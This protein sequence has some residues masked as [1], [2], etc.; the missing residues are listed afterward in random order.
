MDICVECGTPISQG[1][2]KLIDGAAFH[3]HEQ[4]AQRILRQA[5][6]EK[7]AEM[8]ENRGSYLTGA[9]GALIGAALGA[10]VWALVLKMGYVASIVGLL[11]AFLAVKGYDLF[12]GRQGRGKLLILLVS[13]VFGVVM[14]TFGMVMMEILAVIEELYLSHSDIPAM[15]QLLL[16]DAEFLGAIGKELLLGL[17]YAALGAWGIMRQTGRQVAEFKMTDLT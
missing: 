1:A 2:W 4:C 12:R 10:V 7:E 13:V 5:E 6:A 14:G 16:E 17:L 11:I 3:L 9:V 15:L 8:P